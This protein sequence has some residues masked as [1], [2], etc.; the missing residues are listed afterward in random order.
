VP[1]RNETRDTPR[2]DAL[3]TCRGLEF[4]A[5][6]SAALETESWNSAGSGIHAGVSAAVRHSCVR[7]FRSISKTTEA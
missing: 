2:S 3:N 1:R 5:T 7:R 6:A 4:A